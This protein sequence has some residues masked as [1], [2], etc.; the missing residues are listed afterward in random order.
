LA[1]E[2]TI[3]W[4]DAVRSSARDEPVTT[5]P[6]DSAVVRLDVSRATEEPVVFGPCFGVYCEPTRP[7]ENVPAVLIVNTSA[8][9]HI[10]DGR[11]S[12]LLARRLAAQGIASLRMDF[13]GFG[14]ST[15][16]A[17]EVTV[18]SVFSEQA[19]RDA[20]SGADWLGT[21]GH[22]GVVSF[23]VCSGAYVSLHLCARHPAVVGAYAVNLPK[24]FHGPT[25]GPDLALWKVYRR[26]LFD[27]KKWRKMFRGGATSP[28]VIARGFCCQAARRVKFAATR[29][30]AGKEEFGIADPHIRTLVRLLYEK[31]ARVRMI[32]GE[33]DTGL[34]VAKA[35]LG[36]NFEALRHCPGVEASVSPEL[37]HAVL[38]PQA[39]HAVLTDVERWVRNELLMRSAPVGVGDTQAEAGAQGRAE[40]EAV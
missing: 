33:L 38:A 5:A 39:R 26:S 21:R 4:L 22:A 2:R 40:A 28:I 7:E 20:A 32:F 9:H 16:A 3:R 14:D 27:P 15:P 30:L 8:G 36:A 6:N 1:F 12:V 17:K 13:G 11:L 18:D 10:G 23:G 34:P 24:F 19:C 31:R 25:A 35:H 29:L 37:D